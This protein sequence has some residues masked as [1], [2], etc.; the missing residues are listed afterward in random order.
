LPYNFTNVQCDVYLTPQTECISL[1]V[2]N[3]EKLTCIFHTKYGGW[4][5]IQTSKI[6]MFKL[7]VLQIREQLPLFVSI[8]EMSAVFE[9]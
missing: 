1:V 5:D 6:F 3:S 9:L 7:R 8:L 2:I 4:G